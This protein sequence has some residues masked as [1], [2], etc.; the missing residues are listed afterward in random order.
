MGVENTQTT[1]NK[2]STN[3]SLVYGKLRCPYKPKVFREPAQCAVH[4]MV[5]STKYRYREHRFAA[6]KRGVILKQEG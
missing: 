1:E 4:Q 2:C 5:F 3:N 6:L